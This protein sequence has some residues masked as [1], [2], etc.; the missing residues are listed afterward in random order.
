MSIWKRYTHEYT[1]GEKLKM[2]YMNI[3]Y[4]LN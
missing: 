2:K 3:V 1:H 4:V